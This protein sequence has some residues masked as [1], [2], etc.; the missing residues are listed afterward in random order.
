MCL[1]KKGIIQLF[2]PGSLA[3][4]HKIYSNEYFIKKKIL[5]VQEY[6]SNGEYLFWQTLA[7]RIKPNPLHNEKSIKCLISLTVEKPDIPLNMLKY[8]LSQVHK[9]V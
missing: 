5:F 7:V 8:H 6:Y 4:N 2:S 1:P 9:N 3:V